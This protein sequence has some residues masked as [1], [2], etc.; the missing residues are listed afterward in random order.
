LPISINPSYPIY[1][2]AYPIPYPISAPIGPPIVNPNNPHFYASINA[3]IPLPRSSTEPNKDCNTF[4]TTGI[5]WFNEFTISSN[6]INPDAN[7]G[8]Y[9]VNNVFPNPYPI[10]APYSPLPTAVFAV[11]S[12]GSVLIFSKI[13][14]CYSFSVFNLNSKYWFGNF[15]NSLM[16]VNN[17]IILSNEDDDSIGN[18]LLIFPF[19]IEFANVD[20]ESWKNNEYSFIWD[21]FSTI[22][23]Y[24]VFNFYKIS[25]LN[26]KIFW[27][28]VIFSAIV[29]SNDYEKFYDYCSILLTKDDIAEFRFDTILFNEI[30]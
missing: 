12:L 21:K 6:H 10:A 29:F 16:S 24:I 30:S 8:K 9:F 19:E 18:S 7:A 28:C 25:L 27:Y 20:I 3:F 15:N 2:N 23:V 13:L 4:C 5:S 11:V 17:Y 14:D 22:V 1:P 26:D